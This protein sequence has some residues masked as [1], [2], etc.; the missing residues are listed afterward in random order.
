MMR[1]PE[2]SK[3]MEVLCA[4]SFLLFIYLARAHTSTN[5]PSHRKNLPLTFDGLLV[6]DFGFTAH[7]F[8]I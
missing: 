7:L 4:H 8:F 3:V 1:A 2:I 6:N 5:S